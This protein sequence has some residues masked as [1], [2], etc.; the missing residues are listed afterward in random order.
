MPGA[1]QGLAYAGAGCKSGQDIARRL[2]ESDDIYW[3]SFLIFITIGSD[4]VGVGPVK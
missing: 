1:S 4:P 2:I 3:S